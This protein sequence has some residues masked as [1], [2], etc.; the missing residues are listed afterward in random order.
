MQ[1]LRATVLF[2][3]VAAVAGA[4]QAGSNQTAEPSVPKSTCSF[5][6]LSNLRRVSSAPPIEEL[7][8]F[9]P[10]LLL[11]HRVFFPVGTIVAVNRQEGP[12]SCV[13][14]PIGPMG[15][16][17]GLRTGWMQTGLLERLTD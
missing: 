2:A 13:T 6:R 9:D 1:V 15:G 3:F 8:R 4:Q 16:G 11:K 10:S 7:L 5:D 14:G 17:F 12:W